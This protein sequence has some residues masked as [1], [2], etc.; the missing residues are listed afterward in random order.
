MYRRIKGE[1]PMAVDSFGARDRISVDDTSYV[2]FRLDRLD[3][4]ARLPYG[5][6]VLLENLLRNEDGRLL[7]AEQVSA[8]AGWDPVADHASEVQFSTARV[9]MQDFTAVPSVVDQ[10][11]PSPYPTIAALAEPVNR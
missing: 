6:K 1:N 5:L 4:A 3:G 10:P 7:T 8:L 9:S 11:S 2:I